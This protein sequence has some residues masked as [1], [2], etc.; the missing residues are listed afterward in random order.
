VIDHIACPV[1]DERALRVLVAHRH[2]GFAEALAE[3]LGAER[4][5]EVVGLCTDTRKIE[6]ILSLERVDVL[7]V[8]WGFADPDARS[9]IRWMRELAPGLRVA[10]ISS[11]D[12][13]PHAVAAAR[14]GVLAWIE[15]SQSVDQLCDAIRGLSRGEMWFPPSFVTA[16]LSELMR[17]E[18]ERDGN[19]DLVGSLTVRERQILRYLVA[20]LTRS[21]IARELYI[22]PDTVRTHVHN[23]L[24]RLGVH[25]SVAAVAI[26]RRAGVTPWTPPSGV[27]HT[28]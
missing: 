9:E 11:T 8:D 7:L 21:D 14:A 15:T 17:D 26:A 10:V 2:R 19:R 25:D 18:V 22:S 28:T 4:D 13:A 1:G 12:G 6:V 27:P 3:R 5:L 16:A 20:G 24:Q 23:L